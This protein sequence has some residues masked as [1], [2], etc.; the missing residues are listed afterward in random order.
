MDE[1][2]INGGYFVIEPEFLNYIRSDQT[3]LEKEPL[4]KACRKKTLGAFKHD[5]FWQC[6]DTKR[7]LEKLKETLK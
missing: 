3:F 6:V 5:G 4:E 2:W 1:G 7:D